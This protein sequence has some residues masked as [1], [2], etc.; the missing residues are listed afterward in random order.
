MQT[1]KETILSLKDV[2]N[3]C[4]IVDVGDEHIVKLVRL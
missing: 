2:G 4:A 1:G 3:L